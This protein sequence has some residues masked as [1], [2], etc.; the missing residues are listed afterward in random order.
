VTPL[1]VIPGRRS[2]EARGH[3]TPVVSGG[4]FYADAVERAGGLPVVLPP[5]ESI[6][7]I[8]S[9][10]DRCDA[11]VLL[12]GG[13]VSPTQYDQTE[14]AQLFGVDLLIDEFEIA[15]VR[16]AIARNIPVLA[17]C[18]GHQVLNVA[19]GGSLIQHLDSTVEHRDTMHEVQLVPGSLPALAMG[20]H[21]PLVHS[22][23]HQAIDH[24]ASDLEV[25]GTFH[26]GTIEAVQHKTAKWVV[27][28]QW[29]PEDTAAEDAPNQGLFNELVRQA[30][31]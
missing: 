4:R 31:R 2:A 17:I 3:R 27:G 12:G 30:S 9:T 19:L 23:H 14:R 1:V 13:D 25:V 22:F 8:H 5:S 16:H 24:V 18:R 15:A 28:V 11:M 20:T 7:V 6:E 26:D 21:S 10:I 29:H